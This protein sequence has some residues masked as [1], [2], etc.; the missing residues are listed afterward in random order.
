M[1]DDLKRVVAWKNHLINGTD[2]CALC[3]T[4]EG[5]LLKGTVVGVLDSRRP[6]L[7]NYAVHCD[8]NWLT[9]RV[10]VECTIGNNTKTLSLRVDSHG[11]WRRSGQE[12]SEARGCLDVD[13]AVTPATN[14]LPIRRSDLEVGKSES[15]TAA[16]VKFPD[17]EIQLLSQRYTRLAKNMYRYE[18]DT[19]FSAELVV[20]NLGLVTLYP[21]GWER[22]AAM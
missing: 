4:S 8:D 18:S 16:W 2:Y 7:A 5:W 19:G 6:M 14:T 22:I 9:R 21:G 12:L 11:L 15:V 20:D 3:H 10:E 13:L 1:T 17:L